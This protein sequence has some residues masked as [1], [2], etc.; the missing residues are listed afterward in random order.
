MCQFVRWV[1]YT[2]SSGRNP[3]KDSVQTIALCRQRG[4]SAVGGGRT[5]NSGEGI[6]PD[7]SSENLGNEGAN[8][9][10]IYKRGRI[11]WFNLWWRGQ[12][13]HRSTRQGNPRVA[14]QIEAA[15]R[16][17]VA[18]DEVGIVERKPA[19]RLCGTSWRGRRSSTGRPHDESSLHR[20]QPRATSPFQG[21]PFRS[22]HAPRES[23]GL[24]HGAPP[25]RENVLAG[26]CGL[27][28][29]TGSWPV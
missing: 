4:S 5:E 22:D 25:R 23:K 20:Q 7:N 17:D 12:H 6:D 2:S 1:Q 24:R 13:I 16:T 19:S 11:Y 18:K 29:S 15:Y 8:D 21:H 3:T 26:C 10:A 9:M 27:P 14:R 28:L